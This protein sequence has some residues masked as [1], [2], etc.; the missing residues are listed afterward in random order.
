MSL[1]LVIKTFKFIAYIV[2]TT[3]F[4]GLMVHFLKAGDI[5][6]GWEQLVFF[7]KFYSSPEDLKE[8][9]YKS[10]SEA[11]T[12][13]E[14]V[15]DRFE[16][17]ERDSLN[18]IIHSIFGTYLDPK[19]QTIISMLVERKDMTLTEKVKYAEKE[20]ESDAFS[21]KEKEKFREKFAEV[22]K[23]FF[24]F[25]DEDNFEKVKACTHII[26]MESFNPMYHY[27]AIRSTIEFAFNFTD[28]NN[29]GFFT[30]ELMLDRA[31]A[32]HKMKDWEIQ[33]F[34][35]LQAEEVDSAFKVFHGYLEEIKKSELKNKDSLIFH[36]IN[37]F[38]DQLNDTSFLV[39]E[40]EY[41]TQLMDVVVKN[42]KTIF[43]ELRNSKSTAYQEL[44]ALKLLSEIG[45]FEFNFFIK[46]DDLFY[47][48]ME[49]IES[50][51]AEEKHD[52]LS[53]FIDHL[54][55]I[56]SETYTYYIDKLRSSLSHY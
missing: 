50:L 13:Y 26:K 48:F 6:K 36:H 19:S 54:E 14:L 25:S 34:T 41:P 23:L 52:L 2:V 40:K 12:E 3:L 17:I 22:S 24:L 8:K 11:E 33:G 27:N 38:I 4:T 44:V 15:K 56:S 28:I 31:F 32:D 53:E 18:R 43:L 29:I 55:H 16:E 37:V 20:F 47:E 46:Y 35:E 30:K 49:D 42:L 39:L 21:S 45:H 5:H 1:K 10:F 51:P 7:G 9:V